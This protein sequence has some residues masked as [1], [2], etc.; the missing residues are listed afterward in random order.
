MKRGGK[1]KNHS[2]LFSYLEKINI[3]FQMGQSKNK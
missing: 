3:V 2:E 1:E